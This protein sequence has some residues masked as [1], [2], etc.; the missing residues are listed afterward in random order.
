M[1]TSSQEP[2]Q[3]P[4]SS[5]RALGTREQRLQLHT[6]LH[7]HT[8]FILESAIPL[9]KLKIINETDLVKNELDFLNSNFEEVEKILSHRDI[10]EKTEYLVE[11]RNLP[12]S[13]NKWLTA[14]DFG[15]KEILNKYIQKNLGQEETQDR[16]K[17]LVIKKRGRPRKVRQEVA[18]KLITPKEP[19]RPFRSKRLS[20]KYMVSNVSLLTLVLFLLF[21]L[22]VLGNRTV[23]AVGTTKTN[24]QR[25]D[26][27]NMCDLKANLSSNV[28]A[29][30]YS[31]K[32][33]LYGNM[34]RVMDRISTN[35][36]EKRVVILR[37]NVIYLVMDMSVKSRKFQGLMLRHFLVIE[38]QDIEEYINCQ[39]KSVSI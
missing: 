7:L 32:R 21:P 4:N 23:G 8:G 37:I 5:Q 35:L 1:A 20:A 9:N 31:M 22:I 24:I 28:N 36:S 17:E 29:N 14:D 38:A 34:T 26:I 3:Q 25:I 12:N 6:P 2:H 39:V 30:I 16:S 13:H 15:T 33:W 10:N 18:S 11:W 19:E 27:N